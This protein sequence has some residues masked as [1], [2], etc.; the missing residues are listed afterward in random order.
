[1]KP[2]SIFIIIDYDKSSNIVIS[3]WS[4]GPVNA[5]LYD[6]LREFRK[7]LGVEGYYEYLDDV[8]WLFQKKLY[9]SSQIE[10]MLTLKAFL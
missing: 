3:S 9:S 2:I 8:K 6:S 1:M 10:K 5:S 7:T 4:Q